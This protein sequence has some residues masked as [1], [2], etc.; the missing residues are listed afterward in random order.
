MET[1]L[2]FPGDGERPFVANV[3]AFP[4]FAPGGHMLQKKY[5]QISY[6]NAR[7]DSTMREMES[8]V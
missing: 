8:S 4:F 3:W 2:F 5:I 6:G 7:V 1:V